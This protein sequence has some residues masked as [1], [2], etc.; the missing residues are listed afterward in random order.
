MTEGMIAVAVSLVGMICTG[1]NVWVSLRLKAALLESKA[2]V[3]KEVE[4]RYVRKEVCDER[5]DGRQ[6]RRRAYRLEPVE[7][8]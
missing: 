7:P 4:D 8:A 2:Q 1:V 5:H 6:P 3:L